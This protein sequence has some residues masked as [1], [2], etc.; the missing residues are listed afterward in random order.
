MGHRR[1][2]L[3]R[4]ADGGPLDG[5]VEAPID[6]PVQVLQE[7]GVGVFA[8]GKALDPVRRDA[9]PRVIGPY[10]IHDTLRNGVHTGRGGVFRVAYVAHK[11]RNAPGQFSQC[12]GGRG[13]MSRRTIKIF[14]LFLK[15]ALIEIRS[16]PVARVIHSNS[17][18]TALSDGRPGVIPAL[19]LQ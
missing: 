6:P 16:P 3:Q 10:G 14:R 5:E 9:T 7:V 17:T 8:G 12:G 11:I 2:C 4:E 13:A 15:R 1:V 19:G 18:Y